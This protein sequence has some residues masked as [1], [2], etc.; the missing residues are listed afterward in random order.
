V[1]DA[2]LLPGP[3]YGLRTWTV[4]GERGRER[5]AGPHR[6]TPW[7]TGGAWLEATCARTP[8]HAAP[9]HDCDCGIHAWHPSP[10]S[11]RRA[12]AGRRDVAGIVETGGAVEIHEEGFRAQR[13]RPY[14]LVLTRVGNASLIRRLAEAYGAEVVEARGAGEL[15]AWC[16]KRTLGLE[17]PVVAELLGPGQAEEWHRARRRKTRSD[18]VRLAVAV[19]VAALL[20]VLGLEVLGDPPGD[21]VVFGRTGEVHP[22]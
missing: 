18:V 20:V 13:A 3:L 21:R 11:A 10:H 16:R 1:T 6:R 5:L 8:E 4:V 2:P 19:A 17:A 15:L 12:L 7:P 9:V 22:R 14:A